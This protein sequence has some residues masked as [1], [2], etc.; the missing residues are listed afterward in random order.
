M[1]WK[2]EYIFELEDLLR[3]CEQELEDGELRQKITETLSRKQ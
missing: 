2:L 1:D 3:E